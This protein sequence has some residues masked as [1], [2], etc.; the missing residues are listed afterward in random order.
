MKAVNPQDIWSSKSLNVCYESFAQQNLTT[1][2]NYYELRKSLEQIG[3]WQA[4]CLNLR[5]DEAVMNHLIAKNDWDHS[6]DECLKAYFNSDRGSWEEVVI[7]VANPP[8]RNIKL[9]KMISSKYLSDGHNK[10]IT[11]MLNNHDC[12]TYNIQVY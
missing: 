9:A 11:S 1:I 2:N 10:N 6:K 12:R 3:D 4:L 7:A 8:L 5:V